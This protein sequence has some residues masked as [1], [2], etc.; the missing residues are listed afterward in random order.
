MQKGDKLRFGRLVYTVRDLCTDR[1][2]VSE[3]PEE[4]KKEEEEKIGE[5]V[6]EAWK[7]TENN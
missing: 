7:P 5:L 4:M 1:E 3:R 2:R 6:T